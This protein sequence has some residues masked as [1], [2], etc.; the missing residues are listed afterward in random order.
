M[1]SSKFK[2]QELK[3]NLII[4]TAAL[5]ILFLSSSLYFP[6]GTLENDSWVFV[7][8]VNIFLI[9]SLM[10]HYWAD[11]PILAVLIFLSTYYIAPV[12]YFAFDIP[13]VPYTDNVSTDSY[14]RTWIVMTIFLAWL[15][16]FSKIADIYISKP[17]HSYA[18]SKLNGCDIY[19]ANLAFLYWCIAFTI[20]VSMFTGEPVVNVSGLDNYAIYMENLKGQGGILEY[21]LV[22][23]AVGYRIPGR[24]LGKISYGVC[25]AYYLYFTFTR[26]YRIQFLEM[27]LLLSILHLRSLMTPKNVILASVLGFFLMQAY[28]SIKHGASS[29]AEIFTLMAGEELRSNST[30]VFYTSN[31]VIIPLL[32]YR[33]PVCERILSALIAVLAMFIPGSLLP[34]YW[35]STLSAQSV[36]QLP[37]GG[38]G[39]IA[40][41][42]FYWGSHIGVM[43]G[44]AMV[45]TLFVAYCRARTSQVFCLTALLLA[46]SPRWIAY[47]P[48]ANFFRIG[49]YYFLFCLIIDFISA[50]F[51]RVKSVAGLK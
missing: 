39:F 40:G 5:L 26:G 2:R 41:H 11:G 36:T 24:Q 15:I 28:G 48:V 44:A 6:S 21:F 42:Y 10:R 8:V 25:V 34:E 17:I 20:E 13:I 7:L 49:L 22:I 51:R 1:K 27:L 9:F 16:F 50:A 33:I 30:E 4:V 47:E 14:M 3:S 37:G 38:G 31:N 19:H 23:V 29:I 18:N 46:T 12:P 32:E 43:L 35:H 45:V